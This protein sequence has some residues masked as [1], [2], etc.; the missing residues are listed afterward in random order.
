MNTE[1]S[2]KRAPVLSRSSCNSVTPVCLYWETDPI[3]KNLSQIGFID[4]SEYPEKTGDIWRLHRW[5]ESEQSQNVLNHKN[6]SQ[7]WKIRACEVWLTKQGFY[8]AQS[9]W[10]ALTTVRPRVTF[11]GSW[12]SF[13]RYGIYLIQYFKA[14]WRRNSRLKCTRVEENRKSGLSENLGRDGGSEGLYWGA[15]FIAR[16]A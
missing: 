14:I 12:K 9:V 1:L 8:S 15:S 13:S 7:I 2:K 11:W 16:S 10:E 4:E 3:A 6:N 5:L